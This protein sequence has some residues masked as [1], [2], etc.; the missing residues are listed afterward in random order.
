MALFPLSRSTTRHIGG[1]STLLSPVRYPLSR[2]C[3]P[4]S[5]P[6]STGQREC[7]SPGGECASFP[8]RSVRLREISYPLARSEGGE[9]TLFRTAGGLPT[10]S[11]RDQAV[12]FPLQS[13]RLCRGK[14]IM[15]SRPQALRAW[16]RDP[17]R[18]KREPPHPTGPTGQKRRACL[19]ISRRWEWRC[20]RGLTSRLSEISYPPRRR[21]YAQTRLLP[22]YFVKKY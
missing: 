14:Q 20:S 22:L 8:G 9:M 10:H 15:S 21:N 18:K 6:S 2:S 3:K 19:G 4:R 12:R 17:L 1:E 11:F 7:S 5:S 13:L 16:G